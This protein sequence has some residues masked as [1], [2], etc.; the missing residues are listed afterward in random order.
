[1]SSVVRKHVLEGFLTRSNTKRSV[2]LQKMAKGLILLTEK[3]DG[4][5]CVAKTKA[6]ISYTAQL[7]L[8]FVFTYAKRRFCHYEAHKN[9]CLIKNLTYLSYFR[10]N[11]CDK[12][13]AFIS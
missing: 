10:P 8:A 11:R 6:L 5:Y 12:Q 4:L 7:I 1:M 13:K 9:Y 2:Q 3:V